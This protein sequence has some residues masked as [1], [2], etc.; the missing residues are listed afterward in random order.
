MRRLWRP[1]SEPAPQETRV[2]RYTSYLTRDSAGRPLTCR[3]V[4]EDSDATDSPATAPPPPDS[5]RV[6]PPPLPDSR[7]AQPPPLPK[8]TTDPEWDVDTEPFLKNE[9]LAA[10]TRPRLP[11]P[12]DW[13]A[14]EGTPTTSPGTDK[15][16]WPPAKRLPRPR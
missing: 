7:R 13:A 4:I 1:P 2:R 10:L 11:P 8:P 14:E 15:P 6:Q 12:T 5:R 16:A 3:G 9:T